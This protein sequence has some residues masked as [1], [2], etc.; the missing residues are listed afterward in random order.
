MVARKEEDLDLTR[1]VNK[2]RTFEEAGLGTPPRSATGKRVKLSSESGSKE[3]TESLRVMSLTQA[4]SASY[5]KTTEE[6]ENMRLQARLAREGDVGA[7]ADKGDGC[8]NPGGQGDQIMFVD[9]TDRL[10]RPGQSDS[11]TA[12]QLLRSSTN[13]SHGIA[14]GDSAFGAGAPINGFKN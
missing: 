11:V 2:K 13:Q 7:L 9:I 1:R 3:A 14:S 4:A 6:M 5:K 10:K 12:T 8:N